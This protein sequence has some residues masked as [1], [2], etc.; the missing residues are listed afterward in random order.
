MYQLIEKLDDAE[1]KLIS[2]GRIWPYRTPYWEVSIDEFL[3]T[4]GD[5]LT[6]PEDKEKRVFGLWTWL[7]NTIGGEPDRSKI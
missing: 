7:K 3:D 1:I 2:G 5:V 6:D 4:N